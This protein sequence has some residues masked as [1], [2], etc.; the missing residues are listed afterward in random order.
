MGSGLLC[1]QKL[2][3][4]N[5][6]CS[7]NNQLVSIAPRSTPMSRGSA[8]VAATRYA[9]TTNSGYMHNPSGS[10]ASGCV[11]HITARHQWQLLKMCS[12]FANG[13]FFKGHGPRAK[14]F[15]NSFYERGLGLSTGNWRNLTTFLITLRAAARPWPGGPLTGLVW[16]RLQPPARFSQIAADLALGIRQLH[17]SPDVIGNFTPF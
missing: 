12:I 9:T 14:S 1:L 11:M 6:I 4:F 2:Y 16:F 17:T 15:F 8:A 10:Y 3:Q 5:E 7:H 13:Y